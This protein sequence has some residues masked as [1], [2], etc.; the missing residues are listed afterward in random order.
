MGESIRDIIQATRESLWVL[1]H[2][3]LHEM[4]CIVFCY[5]SPHNCFIWLIPIILFEICF[6][7]PTFRG[8]AICYWQR[9]VTWKH[10]RTVFQKDRTSKL[11]HY[12][13]SQQGQSI[14]SQIDWQVLVRSKGC[15]WGQFYLFP[16]QGRIQWDLDHLY[17]YCWICCFFVSLHGSCRQLRKWCTKGITVPRCLNIPDV[18]LQLLCCCLSMLYHIL[19][20]IQ[21]R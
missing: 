4:P 2:Q 16:F 3:L 12:G 9:T 11:F 8:C 18:M 17:V 5:I 13:C 20:I 10:N 15:S 14:K 7:H 6:P 1:F 19:D 21:P